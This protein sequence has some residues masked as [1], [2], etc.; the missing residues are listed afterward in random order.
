MSWNVFS[1]DLDGSRIK[2]GYLE[3]GLSW[4][5]GFGM[6]QLLPGFQEQEN[7]GIIPKSWF[8]GD[9]HPA[10]PSQS[11][12]S[13]K[14]L[15]II[16]KILFFQGLRHSSPTRSREHPKK[17]GNHPQIPFGNHP[18]IPFLLGEAQFSHHK[19]GTPKKKKPS[20]FF[21]AHVSNIYPGHF[22][23]KSSNPEGWIFIPFHA[24]AD[25]FQDERPKPELSVFPSLQIPLNFPF[26]GRTP[27]NPIKDDLSACVSCTE[28]QFPG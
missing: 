17:L 23:R 14:N 2:T 3:E 9:W 1:W 6:L 5:P 25:V 12:N 4:N 20:E 24:G 21:R 11:G 15:G 18:W 16:P 28:P 22:L 10:F 26:P 8:G 7:L 19:P 13:T 27:Q